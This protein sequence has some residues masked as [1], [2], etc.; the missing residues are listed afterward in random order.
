[1][2]D[3]S[4]TS[5]LDEH[6]KNVRHIFRTLRLLGDYQ[7]HGVIIRRVVKKK[8]YQKPPQFA[9]ILQAYEIECK[10]NHYSLRGMR[11][12]LQRLFFF[13]DYLNLR[14]VQDV[15][16]ID[17][18]MISDYLK[19]ICHNHEKSM[20]SILTTLRVFLKFLYVNGYMIDDQSI[21]VP[22]STKYQYP[23]IPSTWKKED[24]VSLLQAVDRANPLGNV[25]MPFC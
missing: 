11:T 14:N 22:S 1:V 17:A 19:T 16:E 25:I 10:E 15:N 3:F 13:V 7:L 2:H 6:P 8:G 20:A 18:V 21:N 5:L 9:E 24:V 4:A 23:K 12:R